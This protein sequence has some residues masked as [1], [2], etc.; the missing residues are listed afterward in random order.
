MFRR[1]TAVIAVASVAACSKAE[2]P[3]TDS[4]AVSAS[5]AP[6]TPAPAAPSASMPSIAMRDASGKELGSLM[7]MEAA[8]GLSV[9]GALR[10]LP[11]G[12]HAIHFHM[13]GKCEAPFETAGSHWNPTN[14]KH[15]SLNPAGPHLGDM[16][17]FNV[18]A[19]S[20]VTISMITRGGT[21]RGAD[22]LLDADGA[23]A[24]I[25]SGPDDLKT[26]PAGNSGAKIACGVVTG[27]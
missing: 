4:T 8:G 23:A 5:V 3:K 25:H 15:G 11:P 21:L 13:T 14:K 2:A 7:V 22:A 26:D 18:A 1:L 12:E 6:G 17:N 16:A 9:T 27:G 24:V 20:S 19:D 10:G